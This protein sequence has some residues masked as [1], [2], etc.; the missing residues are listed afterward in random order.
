[1]DVAVFTIESVL[2]LSHYTTKCNDIKKYAEQKEH[3][4]V[5]ASRDVVLKRRYA[6]SLDIFATN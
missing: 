1:M 6:L 2:T 3:L 5:L 4:I